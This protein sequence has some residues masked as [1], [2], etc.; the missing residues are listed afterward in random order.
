M[1]LHGSRPFTPVF[2]ERPSTRNVGL[3]NQVTVSCGHY[4]SPY[5]AKAEYKQGKFKKNARR[6]LQSLQSRTECQVLILWHEQ[7]PQSFLIT[8]FL[9]RR[10]RFGAGE[11]GIKQVF[12]LPLISR[13]AVGFTDPDNRCQQWLATTVRVRLS[14]TRSRHSSLKPGLK[15]EFPISRRCKTGGG[16][17]G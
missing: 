3:T 9:N 6:H 15:R 17:R 2:S 8:A 7:S 4:P 11:C 16:L 14:S 10:L 1:R 5:R 12:F 13:Q